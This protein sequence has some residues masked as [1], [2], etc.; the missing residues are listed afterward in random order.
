MDDQQ[1]HAAKSATQPPQNP[2]TA[3]VFDDLDS[4]GIALAELRQSGFPPDQIGMAYPENTTG[5]SPAAAE[6]RGAA[7]AGI[8]TAGYP[9]WTMGLAPFAF[10]SVGPMVVLGSLSLARR[11]DG[12]DDL[13]GLISS[14]G[15]HDDVSA[16]LQTRLGRGGVLVAVTATGK[17]AI[18]RNILERNGGHS[19][20]RL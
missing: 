3:A 9:G 4:A 6:K 1:A 13:R 15:L 10:A 8:P 18:A 20:Q 19:L 12:P 2:A 7:V 16:T 14:L 5:H 11:P 17:E